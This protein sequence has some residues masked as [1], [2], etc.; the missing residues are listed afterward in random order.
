MERFSLERFEVLGDAFLKYIVSRH[1]FFS[2]EGL[3]EGKLTRRRSS[4]VNN[5]NL[6]DLA[7]KK[8][9]QVHVQIYQFYLFFTSCML[10]CV[11]LKWKFL[12]FH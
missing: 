7:I 5:S 8:D 10:F 6:Y 11:H 4:I 3:D 2:F 1:S 12:P 9:L